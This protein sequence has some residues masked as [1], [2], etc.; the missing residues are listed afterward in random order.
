[1]TNFDETNFYQYLAKFMANIVEKPYKPWL[2]KPI[3]II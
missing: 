3:H 2:P 1:M